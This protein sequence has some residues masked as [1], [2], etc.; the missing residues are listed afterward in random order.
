[1]FPGPLGS[2]TENHQY[3]RAPFA[4]NKRSSSNLVGWPLWKC[5]PTAAFALASSSLAVG[6][7]PRDHQTCHP[8]SP[9]TAG[10]APVFRSPKRQRH[11]TTSEAIGGPV[12]P[13]RSGSHVES[14]PAPHLA[15]PVLQVKYPCAHLKGIA[16]I[17]GQERACPN[18]INAV[19]CS[20]DV[21]WRIRCA[22]SR[23][24][25]VSTRKRRA[26]AAKPGCGGVRQTRSCPF[27]DPCCMN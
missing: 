2:P 17:I 14:G 16:G 18:R 26:C 20:G 15:I 23:C 21:S 3:R 10:R 25:A 11:P 24:A 22:L 7:L 4:A 19:A 8:L 27:I 13:H 6:V 1:M 12:Q 9:S 5:W